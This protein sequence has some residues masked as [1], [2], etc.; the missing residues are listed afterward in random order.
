MTVEHIET[1]GGR[2]VVEVEGNGPLVICSP[3]IGDTRDAY[4]PRAAYLISIGYRIARIDLLGDGDS[5]SNF[6][7]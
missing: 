6:T 1:D 7:R 5:T 3:G 4:A 2:L